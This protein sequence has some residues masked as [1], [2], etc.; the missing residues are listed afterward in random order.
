MTNAKK[1]GQA[2]DDKE[3]AGMTRG[4]NGDPGIPEH[5]RGRLRPG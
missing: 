2:G 5:V 4:R 1:P 3:G